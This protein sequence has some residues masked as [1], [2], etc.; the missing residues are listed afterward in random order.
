VTRDQVKQR[1]DSIDFLRGLIMVIMALDHVRDYFINIR[2]D[3]LDL[4]QG[5]ATLFLT[6]W[7]THFCAPIFVLLA[8]TSAGLMAATRTKAEL[9]RFLLTRGIW[10]IVVEAVV[11]TYGW[12]FQSP[13]NLIIL[14]VIWAIGVSMLV[15]SILVWLPTWAIATFALTVILGHNILD[16]GLFPAPAQGPA[17]F[18]HFLHNQGFTLDLGLPT[19]SAYPLLPWVGVMPLG[20]SL[21]LLYEKPAKERQTFLIR[22]GLGAVTAFVL[23]RSLG[24]YGEPNGFEAKDNLFHTLLAFVDTTKYPPSLQFLLMTLGPGLLVLA[25]AERWRGRF[26]NWMVIFGRVPFFYYVLHI[27]V[28]HLAALLAAELQ[29]VGAN[30]LTQA[31]FSFPPEYGFSLHF[32]WLFWLALVI[33]LFPA[34]KWF[35]GVKARR[36]DWWMSY[37]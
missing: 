15:M 7:I 11:I 16:Y 3:P 14:Q 4:D 26:I 21:A 27:Y 22:I 13:T 23:L 19:A 6:R 2:F 35:A 10:L 17:P 30:A 31:F 24:L 34:C 1:L 12:T 25:Y 9:S 32:V 20:Y 28:I 36:K 8:G 5:G 33:L 18:W 29:G 37:L